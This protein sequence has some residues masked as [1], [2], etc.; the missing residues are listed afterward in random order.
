LPII[1][2]QLLPFAIKFGSASNLVQKAH[3]HDMVLDWE[4]YSNALHKNDLHL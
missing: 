3:Q 1:C 4:P 2:E